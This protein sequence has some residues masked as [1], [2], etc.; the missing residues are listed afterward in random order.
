MS[1]MTFTVRP[2]VAGDAAAARQLGFEAFGVPS[3][4]PTEPARI[5]QPDA[6]GSAPSTA[7]CSWGQVI[8]RAYD[9]WFGGVLV[10]T[11]GSRA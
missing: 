5:D 4:P 11:S 1:P 9:S 2:L 3:T 7:T 8:D 6:P 10:P